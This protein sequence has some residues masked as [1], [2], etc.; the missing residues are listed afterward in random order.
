METITLHSGTKIAVSTQ[1]TTG[2]R[3]PYT[4]SVSTDFSTESILKSAELVSL[5]EAIANAMSLYK[6]RLVPLDVIKYGG[7]TE[8]YYHTD[9]INQEIINPTQVMFGYSHGLGRPYQEYTRVLIVKGNKRLICRMQDAE[10][11]SELIDL[12]PA[13]LTV[14][15]LCNIFNVYSVDYEDDPYYYDKELDPLHNRHTEDLYNFR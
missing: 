2:F 5:D 14:Y 13:L 6:I 12:K 15:S 7:I 3:D 11:K 10:V 9:I 1:E 4:G 8:I